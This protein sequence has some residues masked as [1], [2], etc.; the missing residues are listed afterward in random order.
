MNEL[1][2]LCSDFLSLVA[3]RKCNPFVLRLIESIN[4]LINWAKIKTI[5]CSFATEN[6]EIHEAKRNETEDNENINIAAEFRFCFVFANFAFRPMMPMTNA[7]VIRW[8]TERDE[9]NEHEMKSESAGVASFSFFFHSFRL[10]F[11]FLYECCIEWFPHHFRYV[12]CMYVRR[13]RMEDAKK[14]AAHSFIHT[15]HHSTYVGKTKRF[16]KPKKKREPCVMLT[17]SWWDC[18]WVNA[19]NNSSKDSTS[20]CNETPKTKWNDHEWERDCDVRD[21]STIGQ[22]LLL[23]LFVFCFIPLSSSVPNSLSSAFHQRRH[24][25]NCQKKSKRNTR[26]EFG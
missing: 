7:D 24:Q 12:L 13:Q 22:F 6:N 18:R 25:R 8:E 26:S 21:N 23:I 14:D 19:H 9:I 17:K 20:T 10:G 15:L 1:F 2:G 16:A 4:R 11:R 5:F 3:V